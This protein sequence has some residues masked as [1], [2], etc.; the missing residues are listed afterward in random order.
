LTDY[1]WG[2]L[3]NPYGYYKHGPADN[4]IDGGHHLEATMAYRVSDK[5]PL[6][7][8]W[9]TWIA[10]ADART[11]SDKR[12]YSS[13]I[14]VSYDIA[15]PAQVTLTPSIGFTPW[16]GYYHDKAAVTDMSL[17]AS[18]SIGVSEKISMPLF[19]QAIASPI[20][21]H[22]YLVAGIGLGF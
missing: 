10:G 6:T 18:K 15:C 21:D 4:P 11:S 7:I 13:Y 22:V 20:N 1:W 2:G 9:S 17:K 12:C 16:K 14:N 3:H 8:S 5:Y 19:I